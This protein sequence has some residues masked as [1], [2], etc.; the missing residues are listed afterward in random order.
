MTAPQTRMIDTDTC[1]LCLH[2]W[3]AELRGQAPTLLLIHATGFHGR[4]WDRLLPYLGARHVIAPDL[5]GHG[6]SDSAPVT[7]WRDLARDLTGLLDAL[8]LAA[9][10]AAGHSVGGATA[11]LAA[12]ARPD[13]FGKLILIDPV[14][15]RPELYDQGQN[16]PTGLPQDHPVARRRAGFASVEAMR[17]QLG[18]KPPYVLFDAGVMEDY[19][20]FGTEETAD[21]TR[22][23][24]CD[25]AFEA[26]IYQT[27]LAYADTHKAVR[28]L[29]TPALVIRAQQPVTPEDLRDFRFSPTD[30]GLA[31]HLPHAHDLALPQFTHFIPQ[32]SPAFAAGLIL[33]GEASL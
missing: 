32:Q 28:D 16:R 14:I 7:D 23:L 5:R 10:T 29:Q 26:S 18:A 19:C 2:E 30:P 9:V 20:R 21:G 15:M 13:L 4:C 8:D 6:Q 33:A 24:L 3:G 31:A 22:R 12:L 11:S 25:P 27:A 1:R 17:D